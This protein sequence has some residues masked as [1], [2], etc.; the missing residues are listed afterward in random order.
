MHRLS[1][2]PAWYAAASAPADRRAGS[3]RAGPVNMNGP[4]WRG[5]PLS[6]LRAGETVSAVLVQVTELGLASSPLSQPLEIGDARTSAR[7]RRSP[8][9]STPAR[10]SSPHR[11]E[12]A[13]SPGRCPGASPPAGSGLV[14]D[15]LRSRCRSSGG[16]AVRGQQARCRH[17][18]R[19]R[20]KCDH[21]PA[22]DISRLHRILHAGGQETAAVLRCWPRPSRARLRTRGRPNHRDTPCDTIDPLDRRSQRGRSGAG[23]TLR[24][25]LGIGAIGTGA[26][27]RSSRTASRACH[28]P[29]CPGHRS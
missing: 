15:P 18:R 27:S 5:D 13:T 12:F 17:D 8:D 19:V 26:D 4:C 22:H 14:S 3:G 6:R 9:P 2:G 29:G 11:R 21:R 10:S 23:R 1:P 16:E 24:P 7:R 28:L 25:G 20:T